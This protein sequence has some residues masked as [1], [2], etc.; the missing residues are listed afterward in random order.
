[1]MI[2]STR[3]SSAIET[4]H[5]ENVLNTILYFLFIIVGVIL[6]KF[7]TPVGHK[8]AE[9]YKKIGIEV[10]HVLYEKQFVFI[11][12]LFM[13]VGFLGATGLLSQM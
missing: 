7:K 1:M 8:A 6:I 9:L 4:A 3:E 5:M 10:P 13:I 2:G 11:G 12:V